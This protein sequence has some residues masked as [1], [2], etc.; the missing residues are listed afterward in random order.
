M[1]FKTGRG[2]GRV[3]KRV[4]QEK[5]DATPAPPCFSIVARGRERGAG[6]K[7]DPWW[8][9]GFIS[10][11]LRREVTRREERVTWLK[12]SP[13]LLLYIYIYIFNSRSLSLYI[14]WTRFLSWRRKFFEIFIERVPQFNGKKRKKRSWKFNDSS[15]SRKMFRNSRSRLSRV[16]IFLEIIKT[17]SY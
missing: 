17:R 14:S 5:C 6:T 8:T 7:V 1:N 3:L 12:I 10:R 16:I 11:I 9:D 13:F 2:G 4:Y 15:I